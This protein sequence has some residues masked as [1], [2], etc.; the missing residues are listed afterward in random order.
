MRMTY[1]QF[2]LLETLLPQLPAL[3]E[4][5]HHNRWAFMGHQV[6]LSEVMAVW[7]WENVAFVA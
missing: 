6:I 3:S 5:F 4:L 7:S 1:S 2:L